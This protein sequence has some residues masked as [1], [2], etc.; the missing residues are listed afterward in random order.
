MNKR[1]FLHYKLMASAAIDANLALQGVE[2]INRLRIYRAQAQL[3]PG[4]AAGG[5]ELALRLNEEGAPPPR[6]KQKLYGSI[7]T[8]NLGNTASGRPRTKLS[9]AGEDV[10]GQYEAIN[11]SY[12]GSQ[13]TNAL[14]A[15]ASLPIGYNTF[16]ATYAYSEYQNLLGDAILLFGDSRSGTLGWNRVL[17]RARYGVT[18]VDLTLTTRRSRRIINEVSLTPQ[19]FTIAKLAINH[20]VKGESGYFS[21]EAGYNRGTKLRNATQDLPGQPS[22][23]A[24][25]QFSKVDMAI[26]A[27]YNLPA[28]F[29]IRHGSNLQYTRR[30]LYSG[31]QVFVG[32]AGSVRGVTE[33]G[34]AGDTG[35][36]MQNELRYAGIPTIPFRETKVDPFI[37]VDHGRAQLVVNKHWQQAASAVAGLRI[38]GK[39]FSGEISYGRTLSAPKFNDTKSNTKGQLSA[40][41]SI[42]F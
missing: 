14:V 27:V 16:S 7:G 21:V 9:L 22:G 32:G 10:L 20:A 18:S 40:S 17:N 38:A 29:S 42:N 15:G 31:D 37:G 36:F 41:F 2:Q 11:F 30:G 4:K 3:L 24:H 12:T 1:E 23:A 5:S 19:R 6:W 35:Y 33:G 13:D 39:G 8:D 28:K 34:F 26:N 25:A